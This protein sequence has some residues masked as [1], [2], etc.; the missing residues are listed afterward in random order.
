MPT[1]VPVDARG[2]LVAVWP[3]ALE[4]A[5]APLAIRAAERSGARS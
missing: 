3:G 4:P 2:R 1:N 5:T